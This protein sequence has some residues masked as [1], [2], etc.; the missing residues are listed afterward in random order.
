MALFFFFIGRPNF[1]KGTSGTIR[2]SE[3]VHKLKPDMYVLPPGDKLHARV[4]HSYIEVTKSALVD[5]HQQECIPNSGSA[6]Q[7]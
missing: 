6:I 1:D 4:A 5:V 7:R 3:T 2:S